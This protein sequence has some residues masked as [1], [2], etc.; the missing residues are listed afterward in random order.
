[1]KDESKGFRILKPNLVLI[2]G[3]KATR[4]VNGKVNQVVNIDYSVGIR[5]VMQDIEYFRQNGVEIED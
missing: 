4:Y 2:E 1:M 5:N 3:T